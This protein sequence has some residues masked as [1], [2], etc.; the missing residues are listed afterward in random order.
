[1]KSLKF[2]IC[3][4]FLFI[5]I[6]KM[7]AQ[8]DI[9]ASGGNATS[10]SGKVSYSIGQVAYTVSTG[11]GGTLNQGVQQP[12]KIETLGNDDFP[13][14]TL[15]MT[16]YPNPTTSML[17][18]KINNFNFI[19]L[20]YILT[21]MAGKQLQSQKIT[22]IESQIQLENLPQSIYFLNISDNKKQLKTFKIIKN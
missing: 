15:L 4:L 20:E 3:F 2:F 12:F 16:I 22:E 19:N 21:D 11:T 14:I 10:P 8:K 7:T 17:N 9:V 13:N 5:F 1:M 6:P 18:L